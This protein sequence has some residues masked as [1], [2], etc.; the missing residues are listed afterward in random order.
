MNKRHK[1]V[2]P[3]AVVILLVAPAMQAQEFPTKPIRIVVPSS[4]GGGTDILARQLA[5]KLTERWGQQVVVDNRPGAGQMIGISLVAKSPPD[6]YTLVMTATPLALN[7]ALYRKLPY[8]PIRDFAPITQIA[9]MPNLLVAHPALPARNVKQLI[10]LAKSRPGEVAYGSS[11]FGTGPHLSMEL[12]NYMAGITLQHVPYKGSAPG[13]LD[14]ISGHVHLLMSTLLPPLPHLKTGRLR[15]LG[16]TSARRVSSLPDV[17]TVIEGGVAGYDVVGWYGVVA[18][19]GTP[20]PVITKLHKDFVAAIHTPE[21]REKLAADGAEAV[22]SK[23]E[24]FSALIK[25]E[26][27]RW[28]KVVEAAKIPRQ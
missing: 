27:D 14:T 2:L 18:P 20:Q 12:L 11:G 28:T 15:A 10:A 9:A 4:P 3:A 17:P 26:I 7:T 23:P 16:V 21:T 1:V 25:S 5:V 8:D 19:A 24:E 6:G 22:G 13:L